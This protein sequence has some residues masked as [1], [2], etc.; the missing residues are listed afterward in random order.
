[1]PA[2]NASQKSK[3][4]YLLIAAA[5]VVIIAIGAYAIISGNGKNGTEQAKVSKEDALKAREKGLDFYKKGDWDGALGEFKKAVAGDPKDSYALTQLA[6]SYERKGQLDEAFKQ[7][8]AL[9]KLNA[10]SADAHYNMGRILV[11][12]KELDKAIVELEAAAKMNPNFTAARMDLARAY[13]EKKEFDKALT[14]Y[15]ELEKIISK[16]DYFLSRIYSAKGDIFKQK[17]Q[18]SN[19]IASFEKALELDSN[20][21]DAQ[22]GLDGLK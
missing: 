16:D 10:E 8:E 3:S 18:R 11:Q 22:T 6:Y 4:K 2:T 19:A 17:G 1:M 7:Y 13:V 21:T 5:L 20:N 15:G 12:K 14:T 9:L